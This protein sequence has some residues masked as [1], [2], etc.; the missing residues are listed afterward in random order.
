M[1]DPS[2]TLSIATD[3]CEYPNGLAFSPDEKLLYVSISR[4]NENCIEEKKQGII[5][6]HQFI[7]VFEVNSD[8]TLSNNRIFADM[9]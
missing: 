4:L 7:R 2:N 5:C 1:F 6:K 9:S 3:E 8:G